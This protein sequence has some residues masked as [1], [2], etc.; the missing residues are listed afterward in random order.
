MVQVIVRV[1]KNAM[2]MDTSGSK[3]MKFNKEKLIN[4]MT[5]LLS[6]FTLVTGIGMLVAN[7]GSAVYTGFGIINIIA[8]IFGIASVC[9]SF[10]FVNKMRYQYDKK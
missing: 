2:G 4:L 7:F 5:F 8:F 3:N 9:I 6:V 10:Y 1:V